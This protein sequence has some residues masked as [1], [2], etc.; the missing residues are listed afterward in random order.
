MSEIGKSVLLLKEAGAL[1]DPKT[2][3][4]YNPFDGQLTFL[5]EV[6][7]SLPLNIELGKVGRLHAVPLLTLVAGLGLVLLN[8]YFL[9]DNY[10]LTSNLCSTSSLVSE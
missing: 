2:P 4:L 6:L 7:A 10:H 9:R 5:G 8:F 1:A 3:S